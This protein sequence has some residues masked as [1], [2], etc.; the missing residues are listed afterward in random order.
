MHYNLNYGNILTKLN[1][2]QD[3]YQHA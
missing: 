1:Y 2:G 3:V